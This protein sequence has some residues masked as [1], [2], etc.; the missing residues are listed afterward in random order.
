MRCS[1]FLL[2]VSDYKRLNTS[3]YFII[4]TFRTEIKAR[5]GSRGG[6]GAI[7]SSKT[8]ESNFTH[9]DFVQFG[10]QHSQYEVFLPSIVLSQQCYE[11]YFI[12]LTVVNL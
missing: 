6:G 5:G 2:A 4:N 10:K 12:S 1:L 3:L 9:H 11:V 8:W 7:A